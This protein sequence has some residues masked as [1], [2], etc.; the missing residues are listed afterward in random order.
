V[1]SA[2]PSQ[3]PPKR[4]R[5]GVQTRGAATRGEWLDLVR[6]AEELGYSNLTVPDHLDAQLGPIAAL[7]AAACVTTVLR[8]GHLVLCNDYRHPVV[9]AKELATLDLLSEGRL[10][11]AVGAGHDRKDY[12]MAGMTFDRPGVRIDRL[13]EGLEVIRGAMGPQSFSYDGTYYRVSDLDGQPKPI[14]KSP[15][16]LVG[17]GGDRMLRL[18][19]EYADIVGINCAV[20]PGAV[21]AGVLRSPLPIPRISAAS[22]S[23]VFEEDFRR[24][25]DVVRAAAGPRFGD[26]EL[27]VRGFVTAV[28]ADR[29]A[30]LDR[31]SADIEQ[32]LARVETS[33]L[34]LVGSVDRIVDDLI[35]RRE[36]LGISHIVVGCAEMAE[37]APVVAKLAGT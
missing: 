25:I 28:T 7:A 26:I 35:A 30:V 27:S 17:G 6:R 23:A 34:F 14:Q 1:T 3:Q 18:A 4:F 9:L 20:V 31:L 13:R 29:V 11:M 12:D 2:H 19:A 10:D 22:W 5:F 36:S 16:L 21:P 33:P 8:L 37:F 24:K 32:P 15:R